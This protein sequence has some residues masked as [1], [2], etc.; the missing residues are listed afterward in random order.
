[1]QSSKVHL[2]GGLSPEGGGG[3]VP[4]SR[5]PLNSLSTRVPDGTFCNNGREKVNDSI[6]ENKSSTSNITALVHILT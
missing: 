5:T 2:P 3:G 4:T 6:E 1:M